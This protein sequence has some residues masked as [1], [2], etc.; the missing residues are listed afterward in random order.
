VTVGQLEASNRIFDPSSIQPG[1]VLRTPAKGI[2]HL[3]KAGQ[4][5][6]DIAATYAVPLKEI[7]SLNQIADPSLIRAGEE[8][9]IPPSVVSPWASVMHLSKGAES[10]FI[11]PLLGD[12][13]SPFGWRTHPVLGYRHEHNGIDIDVQEGTTVHAASYGRV[14]FTGDQEGYGTYVAIAHEDGYITGYGH[15]SK[16]LVHKGQFVEAGQA[17]ALSGNTGI[18]NGPHLHFEIRNGPF[19]IDPA[20]YLP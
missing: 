18:S 1:R 12:V 13:V 9:V 19:A 15:L 2:L 16:V 14:V 17:I 8:L 4:T 6:A 5:L 11:W 20:R 7:V 3:I 10:R